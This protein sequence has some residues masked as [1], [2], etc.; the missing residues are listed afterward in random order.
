MATVLNLI[1]PPEI[2]EEEEERVVDREEDVESG[3]QVGHVDEKEKDG[4][5]S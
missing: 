3:E 5:S 2:V 1:L 4:D